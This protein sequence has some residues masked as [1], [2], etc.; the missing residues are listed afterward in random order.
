MLTG[1][2][3]LVLKDIDNQNQSGFILLCIKMEE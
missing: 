2:I 3:K 1:I